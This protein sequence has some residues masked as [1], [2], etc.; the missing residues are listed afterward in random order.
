MTVP[1]A[2]VVLLRHGDIGVKSAHV[3]AEMEG[4]LADRVAAMLDERGVEGTVAHE[5]GR[6][7]VRTD[8]AEMAT[9][10]VTDVF[11][12]KS[13]SPARTVPPR[14][15]AIT[16]ALAETARTTYDGGT[17]AVDARRVGEHDF[18]SHDVG[19]AGGD[20]IWTAVADEFDPAVDLDDPDHQFF[21]EVRDD[22]AFV[23]LEK[24]EGP[25]GFPIGTQAPLV[26]LVSGGIDSPVAAWQAMRRGSPVIPLY[27]DLGEYGGADHRARALSTI[28]TLSRY[29]PDQD[30]RPRVVKIGE[31]AD[32]LVQ[33]IE[34]TRMLSFRRLMYR[35][36]EHVAEQ[37]GA[38]GIVTGEALGQKS[39]QTVRNIDSVDRATAMPIHRPLSTWDKQEIVAAA[40]KI[41]TYEDSTIDAGCDRIA[42]DKPA[43]RATVGAVEAAEPD[44]LFE[45]AADAAET[46]TVVEPS[47]PVEGRP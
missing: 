36:A 32:R 2:D 43:T 30:M 34:S 16:D 1:G 5:W 29:A 40:R 9:E 7:F 8:T 6:L 23:F 14:I 3:Q 4:V 22:E 17:F 37:A 42:P 25:G 44:A 12:V 19:R 33:S 18:S 24:R 31:Y 21:V 13:A 47:P 27:L 28:D 15:H 20:A 39:S 45:W 11:G 35:I 46:V 10:A 38:A 26:T 41:G